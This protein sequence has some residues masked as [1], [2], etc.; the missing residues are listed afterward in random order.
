M[1]KKFIINLKISLV[2]RLGRGLKFIDAPKDPK[3]YMLDRDTEAFMR[4]MRIHY[5]LANKKGKRIHRF[6]PASS[7][8]PLSTPSLDLENYLESTRLELFII[9]HDNLT[10]PERQALKV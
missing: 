10:K 9:T 8:H 1:N 7:W 2:Q 6:K 4:K 5:L 3:A